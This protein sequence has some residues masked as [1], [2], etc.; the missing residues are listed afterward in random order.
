MR[1]LLGHPGVPMKLTTERYAGI[2]PYEKMS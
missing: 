2:F 1:V